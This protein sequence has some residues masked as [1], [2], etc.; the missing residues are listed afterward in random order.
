MPYFQTNIFF[1]VYLRVFV[2]QT[3]NKFYLMTLPFVIIGSNSC[4][5]K[6]CFLAPINIIFNADFMYNINY[7]FRNIFLY[8]MKT[9]HPFAMNRFI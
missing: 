4:I 1:N 8:N 2:T 6:K 7:T 9:S 3:L 5:N